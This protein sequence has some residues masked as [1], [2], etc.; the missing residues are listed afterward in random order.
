MCRRRASHQ[1]TA[2]WRALTL[3]LSRSRSRSLI[4]T[5]STSLRPSLS[6]SLSLTLTLTLT[7]TQEKRAAKRLKR[8]LRREKLL[9]MQREEFMRERTHEP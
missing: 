3:T 7:R 8:E 1:G 5:P 2:Q 4:L 9:G 6:L